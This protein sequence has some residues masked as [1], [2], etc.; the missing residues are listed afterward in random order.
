MRRV[1]SWMRRRACAVD[2]A[3]GAQDIERDQ[4]PEGVPNEDVTAARFVKAG[5][6][7]PPCMHELVD[8]AHDRELYGR[9]CRWLLVEQDIA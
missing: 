2:D 9:T 5:V 3:E 7:P 1:H 8:A 6:V 4:T